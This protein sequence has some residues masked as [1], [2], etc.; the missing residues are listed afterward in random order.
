MF[1][2]VSITRGRGPMRVPEADPAVFLRVVLACLPNHM[3]FYA[4]AVVSRRLAPFAAIF[5]SRVPVAFWQ[6]H[7]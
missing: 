5:V 2:R 7:T 6:D 3:C 4:S 1:L